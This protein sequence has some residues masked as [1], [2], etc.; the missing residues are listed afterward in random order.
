M[1][2]VDA[3]VMAAWAVQVP[4]SARAARLL[5]EGQ[6]L[7]APEGALT[8]ALEGLRRLAAGGHINDMIL[9]E[10][11]GIIP[12]MLHAIVPDA[13]LITAAMQH[14]TER[15]LPLDAALCLSLAERRGWALAS[16]D[17]Q[18]IKAAGGLLPSERLHLI[19]S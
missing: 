19:Q 17:R 4:H 5:E 7:A 6:P 18:F 12:A 13:G 14:A 9:K 11:A 1:I 3:T 16:A 2:V 8:A 15:R 10:A